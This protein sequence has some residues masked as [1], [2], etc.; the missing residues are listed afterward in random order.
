[1]GIRAFQGGSGKMALP[2]KTLYMGFSRGVGRRPQE[3]RF[4]A[5]YIGSVEDRL[6]PAAPQAS[7]SRR[8]SSAAELQHQLRRQPFM[9]TGTGLNL[10]KRRLD[11]FSKRPAKLLTEANLPDSSEDSPWHWSIRCNSI[12]DDT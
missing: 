12:V 2:A 6:P 7:S 9:R 4:S 1:D 10:K 11:R 3:G 8:R 5:A